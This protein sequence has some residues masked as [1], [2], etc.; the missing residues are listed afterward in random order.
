MHIAF[1]VERV[2]E[3]ARNITDAFCYNPYNGSRGDTVNEWFESHQ[4][5]KPHGDETKSFEIGMLF[6]ANKANNCSGNGT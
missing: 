3:R 4:H 1:S 6:Q 5:A 2:K